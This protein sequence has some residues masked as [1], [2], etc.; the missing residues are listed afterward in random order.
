MFKLCRDLGSQ[1]RHILQIHRHTQRHSHIYGTYNYH[2]HSFQ[3]YKPDH[4]PRSRPSTRSSLQRSHRKNHYRNLNS[5]C[6]IQHHIPSLKVGLKYNLEHRDSHTDPN[7]YQVCYTYHRKIHLPDIHLIIK[8][9]SWASSPL[10][11]TRT[12]VSYTKARRSHCLVAPLDTCR[13][14]PHRLNYQNYTQEYCNSCHT[15]NY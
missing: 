3:R 13:S 12:T 7:R 15:P 10:D 14:N 8:Q 1:G 11:R 4:T 9:G 2:K 5:L 6:C